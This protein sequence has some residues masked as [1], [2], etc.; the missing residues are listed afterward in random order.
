MAFEAQKK[1]DFMFVDW[2]ELG[3]DHEPETNV[4]VEEGKGIRGFVE[5]ISADPDD[6]KKLK[7]L[8]LSNVVLVDSKEGKTPDKYEKIGEVERDVYVR[9]NASLTRQVLN[10]E[11]DDFLPVK[12]G[13]E[14]IIVFT[15]RYPTKGKKKGYGMSVYVDRK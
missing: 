1:S 13:D 8:I 12:V 4:V 10:D 6:D 9:G 2:G 11:R 3:E 5:H 7:G 14:V 15:G